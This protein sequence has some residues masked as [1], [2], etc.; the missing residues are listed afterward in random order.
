MGDI[1]VSRP[2]T[3]LESARRQRQVA[4]DEQPCGL[5]WVELLISVCNRFLELNY[6]FHH[7]TVLNSLSLLRSA[8]ACGGNAVVPERT[9]SAEPP[10]V[11]L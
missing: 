5:C 8:C 1:G 2:G 7:R 6:E 3:A 4:Y 9:E 10:N 11:H